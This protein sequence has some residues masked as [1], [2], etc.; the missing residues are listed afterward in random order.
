M[1]E[2]VIIF[3][4]VIA[5]LSSIQR[6]LSMSAMNMMK[7]HMISLEILTV[8]RGDKSEQHQEFARSKDRVDFVKNLKFFC[9]KKWI[10]RHVLDDMEKLV[11]ILNFHNKYK[12]VHIL[13]HKR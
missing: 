5:I 7:I 4:D 3:P 1:R 12:T 2:C 11:S 6:L 10:T 13:R 8:T 9:S